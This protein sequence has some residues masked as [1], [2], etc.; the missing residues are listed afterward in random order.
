MRKSSLND[1]R[2]IGVARGM[3]HVIIADGDKPGVLHHDGRLAALTRKCGFGRRRQSI[4][5][6]AARWMD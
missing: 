3:G 4:A 2:R 1:H 6:N 5:D